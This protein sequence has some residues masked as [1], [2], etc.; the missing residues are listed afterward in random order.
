MKTTT[1]FQIALLLIISISSSCR[2]EENLD[3]RPFYCLIDGEKFLPNGFSGGI[4]S[5]KSIQASYYPN[6]NRFGILVFNEIDGFD[7]TLGMVG[8]TNN[9]SV[10]VIEYVDWRISTFFASHLRT[11]S[12][13][14]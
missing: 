3:D 5:I 2:K 14:T 1:F 10:E 13:I 7:R 8:F 4:F 12:I 6:Q 9:D 11:F